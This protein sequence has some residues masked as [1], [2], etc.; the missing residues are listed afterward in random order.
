MFARDI[1]Y[2]SRLKAS[3]HFLKSMTV[4]VL[5]S[6]LNFNVFRSTVFVNECKI[7]KINSNDFHFQIFWN[8]QWELMR[9]F[10]TTA[11]QLP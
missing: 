9:N 2:K 10:N 7:S 5:S 11:L 3:L 6:N 1:K 8:I 4:S